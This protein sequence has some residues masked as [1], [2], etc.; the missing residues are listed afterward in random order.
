MAAMKIVHIL[1]E[2]QIGGVERHVIDLSNEL[3]KKGHE[4]M[5]ISAGGQMERQLD[6]KV[7]VRHLPVHKKKTR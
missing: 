6:P 4:V 7:L 3:V 2:L 5:V 1:P